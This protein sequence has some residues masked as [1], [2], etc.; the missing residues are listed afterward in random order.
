MDPFY[1]LSKYQKKME[2]N[3]DNNNKNNNNN[4]EIYLRKIDKYSK[5]LS[6]QNKPNN[7]HLKSYEIL[8]D[9]GRIENDVYDIHAKNRMYTH[10][11]FTKII[12]DENLLFGSQQNDILSDDGDMVAYDIRFP[13]DQRKKLMNKIY[14]PEPPNIEH[15]K[16]NY[17]PA[18]FYEEIQFLT[19]E[20]GVPLYNNQDSLK[21]G[22]RGPISMEDFH[23]RQKLRH[24]DH[25]QIPERVV[26]ARGSGAYGTFTC[27]KSMEEFTMANFL[28]QKGKETEIFVRFSQ[29]VGSKGSVDTVRDARGFATKFYTEEGNFDIV[30]NNIPVFFIQD[31]IKFPDIVH[32]IKPEPDNEMP[33]ATGAHDNF[34]DFISLTPES[35]HM[36][37]W[38]ISDIGLPR[39]YRTME[40]A[41]VHSYKFV[42]KDGIAHYVKF[43]WKPHLGI[44]TVD[45][46][47]F[48]MIGGKDIDYLR[49]DLWEAIRRGFYPK[50]DFVVQLMPIEDENNYP[51][52]PLDPTKIWPEHLIPMIKCGELILNKNP[53][54]FFA[55]V[56]QSA[57]HVGNIVPGI[58]LSDDP[59]LQGRLFSYDDT[60]LNRFLST[61]FNEIPV[62]R[63]IARVRNNQRDGFNR[64]RI[65]RG[66]VNYEPNTR[67]RNQPLPGEVID[68]IEH[69]VEHKNEIS[70]PYIMRG[71]GMVVSD[72]KEENQNQPNFWKHSIN[73]GC[74]FRYGNNNNCI[75]PPS[76]ESWKVRAR[77]PKFKDHFSQATG[78]YLA[79]NHKQREHLINAFH[80][81]LGHVQ[82]L[83]IR[84]N[85]IK[86]LNKIHPN[87]AEAVANRLVLE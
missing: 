76:T 60:Q 36:I 68:S 75:L 45:Q 24:F 40:G 62:N 18:P 72:K 12:Y 32:A 27:T 43:H 22:E 44:D 84:R 81:E 78:R 64:M 35:A 82:N 47:I 49:R 6:K 46:K 73:N 61:N 77:G 57:F 4:K 55:E 80:F 41:G 56:E 31:A 11:I 42:R 17:V 8:D 87:L 69:N 20:T 3:T 28:Q 74:P 21:L 14:L 79:M 63:A 71:R 30:A 54:N 9:D 26:H 52:D 65:N 38:V 66:P 39:S 7:I 67:A 16:N 19:T 29:V 23:F 10:G 70:G 1:K 58:D 15:I 85:M 86:F 50:W 83:N 5:E 13:Q 48:G 37:M 51:F 25:E 34:W 59:L 33:Q 53:S 2:A